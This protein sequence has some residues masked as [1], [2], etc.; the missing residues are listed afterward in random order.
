MCFSIFTDVLFMI[1]V[2]LFSFVFVIPP[3][4]GV[5]KHSW[6]FIVLIFVIYL[7]VLANILEAENAPVFSYLW[8]V[9]YGIFA[10]CDVIFICGNFLYYDIHGSGPL[11]PVPIGFIADYGWFTFTPLCNLFLPNAEGV[12]KVATVV[13]Q[14]EL[15]F[16]MKDQTIGCCSGD[17]DD[18]EVEEA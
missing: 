1:S 15:E 4:E 3:T 5:W 18:D 12:R 17:F 10:I 9:V 14:S 16:G 7:V 2:I 13:E 11:F 8:M 6:T